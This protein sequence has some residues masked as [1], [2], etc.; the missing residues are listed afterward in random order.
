MNRQKKF[1][2]DRQRETTRSSKCPKGWKDM[3]L[4]QIKGHMNQLVK[5]KPAAWT[6]EFCG[7]HRRI[8]GQCLICEHGKGPR[9]EGIKL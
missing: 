4:K 5:K 3:N 8:K 9:P 6:C 1:K 7:G 2:L